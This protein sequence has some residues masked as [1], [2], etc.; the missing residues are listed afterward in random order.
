MHWSHDDLTRRTRGIKQRSDNE[1]AISQQV[2]SHRR[3]A[4]QHIQ[5]RESNDID[6]KALEQRRRLIRFI[7]MGRDKQ[8]RRFAP[9][10]QCR[11]RDDAT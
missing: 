10:M 6:T 7:Q 8:M 5:G 11:Q 3:L 2:G 1:H 9:P 4:R